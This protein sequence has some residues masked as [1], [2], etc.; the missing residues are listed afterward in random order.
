MLF[1]EFRRRFEILVLPENRPN[2]SIVDEKLAVEKVLGHID[3]EKSTYRLGLSQVSIP[4][5]FLVW[6]GEREEAFSWIH[7]EKI[8]MKNKKTI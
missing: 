5:G 7:T 1:G 3:L 6:W 4:M 8:G 2:D